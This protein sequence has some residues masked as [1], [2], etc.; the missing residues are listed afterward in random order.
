LALP[1]L[2]PLPAMKTWRP[3][4]Q[5][6]RRSAASRSTPD[7]SVA[8]SVVESRYEKTAKWVLASGRNV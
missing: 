2:P 6:S 5:Q 3:V 1:A 4:F 7:Q 8:S